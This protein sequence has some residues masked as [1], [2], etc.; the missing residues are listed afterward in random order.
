MKSINTLMLANA[1]IVS[2]MMLP[3]AALA[4][5]I[6]LLPE[7]QTLITL[8]V[9]ERIS[10]EQ[11]T[12]IATLRIERENSDAQTLQ[13]EI[14]GAMEEALEEAEGVSEVDV[15]TGYYSVYQYS[16]APQGGRV[17]NVWRGSQSIT[18]QGQ[19]A[20]EVLELAGEIQGMGFVMSELTYT[21]ST[22]KADEVRDSLMESAISRARANAERAAAALGKSEVDI[23]TLDV[24]AALGYSQPQ[25]YARGVA[26]DAMVEK[27]GPVAEAGESEVSLTV[28]VQAVAR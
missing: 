15:A 2:A 20:Q 24:D 8:S 19:D 28:R 7:G 25:M 16:T 22:E 27:A 12:L 18:L 5:D 23:A 13:R 10:V 11:D 1:M 9:T 6:N 14:N 17:A 4:Q 3:V 26:M 21:L